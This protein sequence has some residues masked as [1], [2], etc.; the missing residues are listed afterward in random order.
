[1]HIDAR[2][3]DST[4]LAELG[5]RLQRRRL[6]LDLTQAVT[7]HEAG[8]SKRTLERM[9]AGATVQLSSFIRIL[10][11][12]DLLDVLDQLVPA[13]GPR[14]LDLLKLEGKKRQRAASTHKVAEPGS[15]DPSAWRW[16]EDA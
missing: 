11:V 5:S 3:D 16:G 14:P 12:L 2:L 1:M 9:E 6:D 15:D 7:A 4:L 13:A 8:V 10:R